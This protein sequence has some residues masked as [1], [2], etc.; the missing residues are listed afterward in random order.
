MHIRCAQ[1]LLRWNVLVE[2]VDVSWKLSFSLHRSCPDG[3]ERLRIS[4]TSHFDFIHVLLNCLYFFPPSCCG[5]IHVILFATS[6]VAFCLLF[7]FVPFWSCAV[8]SS[9]SQLKLET[10][11][12]WILHLFHSIFT[13]EPVLCVNIIGNETVIKKKLPYCTPECLSVK[14]VKN[15]EPSTA[16]DI[17]PT[18][19]LLLVSNR[20]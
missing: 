17:E 20:T 4:K 2:R 8:K 16:R 19:S 9:S 5:L 10:F 1:S 6:L 7:Y 13:T 11:L 18:A 12:V 14:D 3:D 15:Q